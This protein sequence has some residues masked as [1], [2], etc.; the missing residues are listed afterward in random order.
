MNIRTD[1]VDDILEH[2]GIKRR[3]GRYPW[4]SGD[5][6]YQNSGKHSG[7]Y[8]L[9]R[10]YQQAMANDSRKNTAKSVLNSILAGLLGGPAAFKVAQTV[11]EEHMNSIHNCDVTDYKTVQDP[12][13]KMDEMDKIPP[14]LP[15]LSK[16]IKAVNPKHDTYGT[17]NNCQYCVVAMDMR[18]RGYDVQA[19]LRNDGGHEEDI[20]KWYNNPPPFTHVKMQP[21]SNETND[22]LRERTYSAVMNQ[23]EKQGEGARGYFGVKFMWGGGHAMYY[24]VENGK[25]NIYDPQNTNDDVTDTLAMAH[26]NGFSY[27][28][29]DNLTPREDGVGDAVIS[30]KKANHKTKRKEW[31]SVEEDNQ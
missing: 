12:V 17:V 21:L 11:Y 30:R 2:Y 7:N 5:R 3:S 14:P 28:R 13:E 31:K 20:R 6:P 18:E 15:K 9:N 24:K 29:L 27:L 10:T 19:R 16:N 1:S 26:P 23:L 25:V 22:S 8:A 4:G